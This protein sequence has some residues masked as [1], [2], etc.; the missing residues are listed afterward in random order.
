MGD[1]FEIELKNGKKEEATLI[2]RIN[3]ENTK[4]E[5]IYYFI[6]NT[7]DNNVSIYASKIV[8]E[9]GK[10]IMKDL[11]NEEERQEAYR[12]F[13]ETYKSLR[14]SENNEKL[15]NVIDDID[16]NEIQNDVTNEI[17]IDDNEDQNIVS[18][19]MNE[20]NQDDIDINNSLE[21]PTEDEEVNLNTDSNLEQI[22]KPIINENLDKPVDEPINLN[23]L[24]DNVVPNLNVENGV[25]NEENKIV[26][27]PSLDLPTESLTQAPNIQPPLP[28]VKV[29]TFEVPAPDIPVSAKPIADISNNIPLNEDE[30]NSILAGN[31]VE[32]PIKKEEVSEVIIKEP[33][34]P[35]KIANSTEAK[36]QTILGV[37]SKHKVPKT[38]IKNEIKKNENVVPLDTILSGSNN[39]QNTT[40]NNIQSFFSNAA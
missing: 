1:K 3:A 40:P 17:N 12:I 26:G 16:S 24:N 4:N 30:V 34:E 35:T 5:Y 20:E 19:D 8:K 37:W 27:M 2:T 33:S 29:P 39:S 6:K 32:N 11:E 23:V 31:K 38:I 14:E 9:D 10:E 25:N 18:I 15:D 36:V 28:E 13:S 21:L 22:D 7:G